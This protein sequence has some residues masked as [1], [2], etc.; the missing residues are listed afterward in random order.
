[1]GFDIDDEETRAQLLGIA[2]AAGGRYLEA[3]GAEELKAALAAAAEEEIPIPFTVYD[4][5]GNEI[6]K[7]TADA[8]SCPL[9]TGVYRIVLGTV[10][11]VEIDGVA[12]EQDRKTTII[13]KKTAHGFTAE[14]K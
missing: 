11:P 10:P 12:I 4:E 9:K 6:L 13:L 1:V 8:G 14:W 2:E 3:A 7:D 5:R